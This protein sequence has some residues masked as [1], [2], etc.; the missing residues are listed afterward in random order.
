MAISFYSPFAYTGTG[1][2]TENGSQGIKIVPGD[3]KRFVITG[4]SGN[5]SYAGQGSVYVGR[6]DG[7]NTSQGNGSGS[8]TLMNVPSSWGASASSIY[9]PGAITTGPGTA[10]ISSIQLA[11][12]YTKLLNIRGTSSYRTLG[13]VYDGPLTSTPSARNFKQFTAKTP[14]GKEAYDTFLHSWSGR[15]V[16]GNYTLTNSALALTLN[17]G[18]KSSAFL[19]DSLTGKQIHLPYNDGSASHTAFGIW[20]NPT[21]GSNGSESYT[22][23]GGASMA[24]PPVRAFG[25][26]GQAIGAATLVDYDPVRGKITN[27]RNYQYNNDQSNS[28]VTHFEGIF[29]TDSGIYQMPFVATSNS[30]VVAGNAYVKRLANGQFSKN[31]IWQTFN[32]GS[33]GT[34]VT[35]DSSAGLGSTGIISSNDAI[36]PFM[37]M[38]DSNAYNELLQK[39]QSLT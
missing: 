14:E 35:N 20:Q 4:T 7:T 2:S 17:T 30:G 5:L 8:W 27:Q 37:S 22:I 32:A 34:V 10:G 15:Y 21:S 25:Q 1:A 36:E 33:L 13:Y 24:K 31:A 39:A 11:G 16:A 26:I 38:M 29:R 12:T 28:F 3:P 23:A 9:G 19:Y 6:I 18:I